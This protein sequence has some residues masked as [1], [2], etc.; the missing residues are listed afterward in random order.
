MNTHERHESGRCPMTGL[1]IIGNIYRSPE[2][3][4]YCAHCAIV[5]DDSEG[6]AMERALLEQ[7]G[8]GSSGETNRRLKR[9]ESN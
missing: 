4:Y 9:N 6:A 8:P 3:D 5:G 1:K 2:G 7:F